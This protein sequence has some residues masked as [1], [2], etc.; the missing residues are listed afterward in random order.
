MWQR[1][2]EPTAD[3][4][5]A[6]ICSLRP[7]AYAAALAAALRQTAHRKWPLPDRPWLQAQTWCDLLFAH[8]PVPP[9]VLRH[10]VPSHLPLGTFDGSAW[11]GVTT[12]DVRGLR[13]R[14][15]PQVPVLSRFPETNVRTYTTVGDKP[16]IFFLSLDARSRLAVGAARHAYRLPYF[17]AD[18]SVK[19]DGDCV[20]YRSDRARPAASLEVRYRP[21][22]R[23][24][25][26]SPAAL[27]TSSRSATASTRSTNVDGYIV[28]TSI[29]R[30]GRCGTP[31][32]PSSATR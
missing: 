10:A 9:E 13:L 31:R 5:E 7:R 19:R 25:R 12:F 20:A 8:S 24:A 32:R 30:R 2:V 16:G 29:I 28:P 26:R 27:S 23:F 6:A 15:M 3:F 11:I 18:M 22:A 1:V 17:R 4:A 21:E 14:G